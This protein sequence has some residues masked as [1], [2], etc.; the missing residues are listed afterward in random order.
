M[1]VRHHMSVLHSFLIKNNFY[2]KM[3]LRPFYFHVSILRPR[4]N[5]NNVKTCVHYFLRNFWFSLNDSPSKNMNDV[6]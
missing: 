3:D 5:T 4:T 1:N 2:D 6:F